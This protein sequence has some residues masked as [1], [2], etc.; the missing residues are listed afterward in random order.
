MC[1]LK[2]NIYT[3]A[4]TIQLARINK[5]FDKTCTTKGI[6][7]FRTEGS[8]YG[9]MV[10]MATYIIQITFDHKK[11]MCLGLCYNIKAV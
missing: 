8:P 7:G 6:P 10:A 1:F 11:S 5:L 4:Q 2:F 9:A 3:T